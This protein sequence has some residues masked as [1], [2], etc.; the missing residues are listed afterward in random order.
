MIGDKEKY[1]CFECDESIIVEQ[2]DEGKVPYLFDCVVPT[3][4]GLMKNDFSKSSAIGRKAT[5]EFY[6]R[7]DALSDKLSIR[8]KTEDTDAISQN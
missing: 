4:G 3:C 7:E 1:S 6:H 2:V 5:H 8:K